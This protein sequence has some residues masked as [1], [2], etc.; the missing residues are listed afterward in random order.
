MEDI[1]IYLNRLHNSQEIWSETADKLGA[2]EIN[3]GEALEKW[4]AEHSELPQVKL[5]VS[6]EKVDNATVDQIIAAFGDRAQVI[7]DEF[8]NIIDE[9]AH[10]TSQSKPRCLVHR[11]GDL[12]AAVHVWIIRRRDMGVY[13]LLQKRSHL[14]DISP[15]CYD[16]SAAGHVSQNGEFRSTAVRETAEEIGLEIPREKLELIGL[17][18]SHYSSGKT[19]DNE[20]R[21]V[22]L[23]RG[24]VDEDSLVLQESE[25]AEVGWAELDEL[26]TVIK[27]EEFK[28][29]LDLDELA[30]IK[31]A[32]F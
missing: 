25:V 18:E 19:H 2:H 22:Y 17:M 8:L 7:E 11:D 3:S 5:Y 27:N 14:K 24:D 12:H 26:L 29:C 10:I 4:L 28:H 9:T 6:D 32:V 23:Y 13:V 15:D 1:E 21:A 16:V 30:M 20:V 31:K